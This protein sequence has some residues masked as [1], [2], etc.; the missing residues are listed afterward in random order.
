MSFDILLLTLL[1]LSPGRNLDHHQKVML[2]VLQL[3][4]Y[5]TYLCATVSTSLARDLGQ[6]YQSPALDHLRTLDSSA[7]I[8]NDELS[9]TVTSLL[10]HPQF[11]KHKDKL[12]KLLSSD[13]SDSEIAEDIAEVVGFDMLE[14]A[15]DLVQHRRNLVEQR[16][17]GVLLTKSRKGNNTAKNEDFSEAAAKKRM[18]EKFRAAAE[19]PLWTG[20]AQSEAEIL[21][22]IYTS[23][24]MTHNHTISTFGSKYLLPIGTTRQYYS[25]YEEVTVPPAKTVPPRS[26]ERLIPCSELPPLAKGSFSGYQSLNRIQSI[27]YHTAFKTNENMLI[28]A[29]TGAGKTDVAMLTILRTID[30]HRSGSV[31]DIA[32]SINRNEFKVIYVAPMKALAAEIVRKLGKRLAWL[33]IKVRELTGDMQLTKAEIAETQIIVTTPEKWDVV[34]RKPTGEGELATQVKLLIIDEVHLLNDERGAVIETIVART[35]RQVESTQ[36]L[37]RIVGLSATLPNYID[38][39]DFLRVSRREGLFYFDSSFRPVPLE[40]HF[41][42]VKGKAGSPA[43]KRALD[44]TAYHFV[45]ELAREGHQV[46]VFVHSRKDTVKSA[47]SLKEFATLDADLDIFDCRHDPQFEFHRREVGKSKNKEMKQLFDYGFGIHH[48]GMLRSDRNLME[49]L[50]EAKVIK[51]LCCT[52]TLAW[53]V[54]LPAHGVVI[55]GTQLYDPSQGK[56]IDLSVL[57]VLQIFGRAGRPGM[58]SS[59]VGFICTSEDK[60]QHYL[61]AV[62]AQHPIESKFAH[63]LLDSLNA[64]ISLG[65]VSNVA[66]GAEWLSYTY[67]FV[68]MR[69][70]P[71]VYGMTHD[72]PVN[73]PDL[74]ER[75]HLM[76]T[77]A[78]R[79][80]AAAGMVQF[81]EEKGS[82]NTTDI[83]RIASKYYVRHASIEVFQKEFRPRM[84]EADVLALLS[85]STEFEQ[86]QVREN[87]VEELKALEAD[88]PCQVKGGT[89]TSAGK[90]N[91]LLQAHIS[92]RTVE[93]FALVSDMLYSADNGG[94]IIRA[95]LEIALSRKWAN[96]SSV[97][98]SMSK[99]VEKRMWGYEHPLAQFDLSTDV[100]YSLG[101]WADEFEISEL[102]SMTAANLGNLI[103]LN[104]RH[105]AALRKAARQFPCLSIS[106]QLR[107]LSHELLQIRLI[108]E[109]TF[110]WSNKIHGSAEPFW[111]WVEDDTGTNILQL[112]KILFQQNTTSLTIDFIIPVT[113]I[114]APFVTVKAISDR[115]IGAET[116]VTVS[117]DNLRMP[118]APLRRTPIVDLPLLRTN[119][120]I[121][122]SHTRRM[123]SKF[124]QFNSIQTQCFW[125]AFNTDLNLLISSSVSSGKSQLAQLAICRAMRSQRQVLV[126]VPRLDHA[127]NT[128][129]RMRQDL[130]VDVNLVTH[131]D[132][133]N[134]HSSSVL[135]AT[136]SCLLRFLS[137]GSRPGLLG[138]L[139]LVVFE[140]L[141]LLDPTY[142]MAASLLLQAIQLS[143]VRVVGVAA[144]LN[145][146]ESL[147]D[148]LGVQRDFSYCFPPVERDQAL[149][150]TFQTFTIP[151]SAALMRAMAKPVY[152]AIRSNAK[153]ESAIVFVPSVGQCAVVVSDLI[154][155]CTL[156]MNLR[157]FL[158]ED[159]SEELL[160]SYV[161]QVQS[162]DIRDGIMRG[163]AVWHNRMNQSDQLLS[164]RLFAEGIVRVLITPRESCWTLPVRAG[165]I[166]VMGTQYTVQKLSGT[167]EADKKVERYVAEYS[168]HE[169]VRMEG[170]AVRHGK[171]GRLH[172]LCQAEHRDTYMRFLTDG[173]PLES[174]VLGDTMGESRSEV[175]QAW[176]TQNRS[177]GLVKTRQDVM[178]LL[179]STFLAHR[180]ERNPTYYDVQETSA[181][182]LSR[183]VDMLWERS[184][185]DNSSV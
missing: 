54:N 87:E 96:A 169:L 109:P 157:G 23:S 133:F 108:V 153:G 101:R 185:A 121:L 65:T 106:P 147:A 140:D 158:G 93:D 70:N 144:A 151:Y 49:R 63:G 98:M 84:T 76:I 120:H 163:L 56:F 75:R 160:E 4:L 37:I 143:P 44:K 16:E 8:S 181:V 118:E 83:G 67:L 81:N 52:A 80:L 134:N 159:V 103:H 142:E 131:P 149:S 110:D 138:A 89:D 53:G 68:R 22:H 1:F 170:R 11:I 173:L 14:L 137:L 139:G 146:G 167:S 38:V 62:T 30:Q 124:K 92:K 73:D 145:N 7:S 90:V 19:R 58:E 105:G 126:V 161:S 183:V 117:F 111:I 182:Y 74:T 171:I 27:V 150:I 164:L 156:S 57:D 35:V 179:S 177:R 100:L 114:Q 59:G 29:P 122:D 69:K 47:E 31:I 104:E 127:R 119:L 99:S 172:I 13:R 175:L 64:E 113:G 51:V 41:V 130:K 178:D 77:I 95:L 25:D 168:V 85:M 166:V 148:W 123:F 78:G 17:S 165:L 36:S 55:K 86:V 28:C 26:T 39:A 45:S 136:T 48:A 132:K 115:W 154:K 82:F 155:Q 33:R 129:H 88:M 112:T 94:R 32:S 43:G 174:Q 6:S 71:M 135:V 12:W 128:F 40:Q 20:T 72:D 42:G 116:E 176:V 9:D 10:E 79:K 18:A 61:E 46:M 152:D 2:T 102:A 125:P 141:E 107:P 24:S 66:E 91:V 21:P 180:L 5:G 60:L 3:F 162:S 50:F 15:T 34:T 97:L 184:G